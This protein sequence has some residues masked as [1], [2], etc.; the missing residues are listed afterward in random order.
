MAQSPNKLKRFAPE[1]RNV[2]FEYA[3]R[4]PITLIPKGFDATDE[5]RATT[6]KEVPTLLAALRAAPDLYEEALEV[7]YRSNRFILDIDSFRN[8]CRLKGKTVQ[9]IRNLYVDL[10]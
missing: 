10:R 6:I 4:L 8:F 1:I 2:I 3:L 5:N 9:L 7:F